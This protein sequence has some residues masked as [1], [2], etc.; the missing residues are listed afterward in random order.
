MGYGYR[1]EIYLNASTGAGT[2]YV[3]K[4]RVEYGFG[5]DGG[6]IIYLDKHSQMD[7]GDIRWTEDDGIT[8]LSYY[9]DEY[10]SSGTPPLYTDVDATFYVKISDDLD[11]DQLIYIYYG[12]QGTSTTTSNGPNTFYEW[13]DADDTGG[14]TKSHMTVTNYGG[15][16]RFYNPTTTNYGYAYRADMSYPSDQ[17]RMLI[18]MNTISLGTTDR[19]LI[20]TYDGFTSHIFSEFEAP[21]QYDQ[22]YYAYWNGSSPLTHGLSWVEGD[23]YV[24]QIT[25]DESQSSNGVDYQ[26][27][28][29]G[30]GTHGLYQS[31]E[32][33]TGSPTHADGISIGDR[34]TGRNLDARVKYFAIM[35]NLDSEPFAKDYGLEESSG[36]FTATTT[37]TMIIISELWGFNTAFIILGLVMI[38]AS[39]LYLV[40]G[41]K[42]AMNGDK[43]F[44]GLVV[45]FMGWALIIGVITP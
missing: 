43:L 5:A 25:V 42:D 3:L 6:Q 22:N 31:N 2:D 20:A 16:L 35:P 27:W 17:W 34:S 7:F 23:E 41:G 30:M 33:R 44:F 8:E 15:Y 12:T 39:A 26:V 29:S 38:P 24:T 40:R 37:T 18:R 9:L 1:T 10:T 21:A 45:F 4:W 11:S 19:A 13:L 14:W 36:A 28:Y 32:F